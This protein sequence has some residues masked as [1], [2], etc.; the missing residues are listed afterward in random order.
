[1]SVSNRLSCMPYLPVAKKID[2]L[3]IPTFNTVSLATVFPTLRISVR[4][5]LKNKAT[6]LVCQTFFTKN[7]KGETRENEFKDLF[8]NV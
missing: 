4:G 8:L 6:L 7:C 2:I 3:Q 5:L 1:M